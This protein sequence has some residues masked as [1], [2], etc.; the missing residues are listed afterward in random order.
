V[1][2]YTAILFKVLSTACFAVMGACARWLGEVFP[3]GQV[4]FFRAFVAFAPMLIFY[5]WRGEIWTAM[6]TSRP[7]GHLARGL[8]GVGSMFFL[9]AALA[10]LP[11]AD[12]T[13]ITFS[14]PLIIVA[15]AGLLLGERVRGYRWSAVILGLVGVLV[16]LAPHLSIKDAAAM[17]DSA[18]LG[19]VFAVL[20]AVFAAGA[21]IQIRRLTSSETTSSIVLYFSLISSL[22]GL[23]TLPLGWVWPDP[24]Q[25]SILLT[26]GFFGGVG[27][28]LMTE[29]YRYAQASLTAPFDYTSI[30]W[31]VIL[32]YIAFGEAP[33]PSVWAGSAIVIAAGLVVIWRERQLILQRR[34]ERDNLPPSPLS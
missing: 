28:I 20:N 25:L 3:V 13:A 27:Q 21:Y 10:R 8:I 17:S 16:I 23:A 14:T 32:G 2:I 24:Q 4:V 9:F 5:A 15:L 12:V 7:F 33:G 22:C 11:I 29:S 30:I 34:L 26:M 18:A 6:N 1:S 19:A 31:A